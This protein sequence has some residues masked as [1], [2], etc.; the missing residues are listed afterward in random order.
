MHILWFVC[1]FDVD[2]LLTETLRCKKALRM[3]YEAAA[4]VYN[5]LGQ[6]SY[7]LDIKPSTSLPLGILWERGY[8]GYLK[9][10]GLP[11]TDEDK[12]RIR[13]NPH[14]YRDDSLRFEQE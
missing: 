9:E 13:H 2:Y 5:P 7:A 14:M 6:E 8:K 10:H 1:D 3:G 11:L 4:K 12:W